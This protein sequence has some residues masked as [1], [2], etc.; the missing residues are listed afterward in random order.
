[1]EQEIAIFVICTV[2]TAFL[3]I[4]AYFL[5][6]TMDR[7]DK[8][9]REI[10]DL[11]D[12]YAQLSD[13]YATKE[14]VREIKENMRKLADDIGFIKENSVRNDEFIRLITR[15]ENKIDNLRGN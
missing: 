15:L 7:S 9:E 12:R 13:K 11:R 3:G 4:V 14:E 5:K 6:R 2:I 1:M 8:Q 10:A